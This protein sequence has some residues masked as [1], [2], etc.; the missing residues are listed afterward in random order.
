MMNNSWG[1][2]YFLKNEDTGLVKIGMSRNLK[3]RIKDLRAT[4][5]GRSA[6]LETVYTNRPR[7]LEKMFHLMFDKYRMNGEWFKL[8]DENDGTFWNQIR[9]YGSIRFD[10]EGVSIEE[11][12][13][14][15]QEQFAH[16]Q[17][18]RILAGTG[19]K[20]TDVNEIYE[21]AYG[22]E[23]CRL[24]RIQIARE[25]VEDKDNH[26]LIRRKGA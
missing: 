13:T 3:S 16:E 26:H 4:V 6:L 25:L 14:P 2:V 21:R 19:I 1:H 10:H 5:P 12:L 20:V 17:V 18:G 7:H 9:L 15:E 22:D 8:P 23:W 24:R 11:P